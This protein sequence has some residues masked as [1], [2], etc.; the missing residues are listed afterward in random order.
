[1]VSL[2]KPEEFQC[3]PIVDSRINLR[4]FLLA[5]AREQLSRFHT[6]L[7]ETNPDFAPTTYIVKSD[8]RV[9]ADY[10]FVLGESSVGGSF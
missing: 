2:D 10:K 6:I 8:L 5:I 9:F 1:M 7:I 3:L 4:G